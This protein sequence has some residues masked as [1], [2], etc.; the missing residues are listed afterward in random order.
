MGDVEHHLGRLPEAERESAESDIQDRLTRELETLGNGVV[1][2]DQ[3]E[4]VL[5]DFGPP[6][7]QAA[8]ATRI[9]RARSQSRLIHSDRVWLGVCGII[10]REAEIPVNLLRGALVVLGLF[11]PLLP[12]LLF[13]Y[14][15]GFF[16][17]YYF[18]RDEELPPLSYTRAAGWAAGAFVVGLVLHLVGQGA[19]ELSSRVVFRFLEQDVQAAEGWNWLEERGFSIL[20]WYVLIFVQIAFLSGLPVPRPWRGTLRRVVYAASAVYTLIVCIGIA[21]Y[22]VGLS[23]TV[24][25]EMG[26][27][28]IFSPYLN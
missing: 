28:A 26:G 3:F 6:S 7:R 22:L 20:L 1:S 14:M 2:D 10:A 9:D 11:P 24:S 4:R 18:T 15:A 21:A 25:D 5:Q 23:V 27:F 8:L 17:L 19:L 13:A 16:A 12:I